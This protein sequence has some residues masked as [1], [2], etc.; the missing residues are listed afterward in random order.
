M[1]SSFCVQ[2]RDTFIYAMSIYAYRNILQKDES[3]CIKM[4]ATMG[5]L[6]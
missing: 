6:S 3:I 5:K 1:R 4:K 2:P